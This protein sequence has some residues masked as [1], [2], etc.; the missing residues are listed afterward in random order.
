MGY[1]FQPAKS[2]SL[3]TIA[4][5]Q[6]S[7][8]RHVVPGSALGSNS[9]VWFPVLS[10]FDS[11]IAAGPERSAGQ[12]SLDTTHGEAGRLQLRAAAAGLL[13]PGREGKGGG[14]KCGGRGTFI[15]HTNGWRL[16]RGPSQ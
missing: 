15:V 10:V 4:I 2:I 1:G 12:A 3:S 14:G 8:P 7:Q 6:F 9:R 13:D 5:R 16:P 11:P